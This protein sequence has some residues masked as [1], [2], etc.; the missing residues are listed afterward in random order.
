MKETKN[1]KKN[2]PLCDT[3]TC[4]MCQN[5]L[6]EWHPA[7]C[8]NKINIKL[9]KGEV[10]FREGDP[11]EGIYFVYSGVIKVYKQWDDDKEL[12]IRFAENG[13]ILG[14]R[15]IG[16]SLDYPIAASALEPSVVCYVSMKFFESTLKV[17]GEL[18]Y[19]LVN[20]FARELRKSERRMRDL[21]HMPVKGRVAGA[22]IKLQKQFGTTPDGFIN[23]TLSRQDLASFAGATY[24][25][26]FRVINELVH[27]QAIRLSGKSIAII[28]PDALAAL[29]LYK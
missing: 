4:F 20:F 21:A 22:L 16:S 17:N 24:E 12:I 15:G 11:V 26:V 29:R 23:I 7:I 27:E 2:S 19:Q 13:A 14:H 25:T 6:E 1:I 10:L 3:K 18:T 28:N 9:K 8:A 5:C